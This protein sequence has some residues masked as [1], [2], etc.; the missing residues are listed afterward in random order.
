MR[1]L[2]HFLVNEYRRKNLAP[3]NIFP[4]FF[5]LDAQT[6][7]NR[8]QSDLVNQSVNHRK[9][10]PAVLPAGVLHDFR[11]R[12]SLRRSSHLVFARCNRAFSARRTLLL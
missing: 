12:A 10:F 1:A 2:G 7:L 9:Y 5:L 4:L 3:R 11:T 6:A 8:A